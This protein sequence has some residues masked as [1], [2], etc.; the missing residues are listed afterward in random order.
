MYRTECVVEFEKGKLTFKLFLSFSM[1]GKHIFKISSLAVFAA[2]KV[3]FCHIV[4]MLCQC[5]CFLGIIHNN[6]VVKIE[7]CDWDRRFS[8][9]FVYHVPILPYL[10]ICV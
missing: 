1:L 10:L 2:W 5:F 6:L 7:T 8:P 3:G 4:I 9:K